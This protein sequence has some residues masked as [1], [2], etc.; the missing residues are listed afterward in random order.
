MIG[1]GAAHR[2]SAPEERGPAYDHRRDGVKLD[3]QPGVGRTGVDPTGQ[4][5]RRQPRHQAG[6]AIDEHEHPANVH[7]REP[8]SLAVAAYGIYLPA[9]GGPRQCQV[10]QHVQRHH[11]QESRRH[12]RDL[13]RAYVGYGLVGEIRD[14]EAPGDYQGQPPCHVHHAERR[15]EGMRQV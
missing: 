9:D 10:T 7:A 14:G 5:Q 8:R 2:A 4:H 11:E 13:L 1:H 6:D 3:T 15:N 12:A